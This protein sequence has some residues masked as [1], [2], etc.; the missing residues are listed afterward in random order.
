M[1][2]KGQRFSNVSLE[3]LYKD[4]LVIQQTLMPESTCCKYQLGLC[5]INPTFIQSVDIISVSET[6]RRTAQR[7]EQGLYCRPII[8]FQ[9]SDYGLARLP[10]FG[11]PNPWLT[12]NMLPARLSDVARDRSFGNTVVPNPT[13]YSEPEICN[14]LIEKNNLIKLKIVM[15]KNRK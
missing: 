1:V 9:H 14:L 7:Q 10:R 5:H 3:L 12:G 2:Q 15:K 8:Y 13:A 4:M 11:V 6:G